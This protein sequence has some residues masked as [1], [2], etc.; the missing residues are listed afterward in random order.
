MSI[1]HIIWQLFTLEAPKGARTFTSNPLPNM[2][3]ES[4]WTI[5]YEFLCYLLVPLVGLGRPRKS[6]DGSCWP[7]SLWRMC[8]LQ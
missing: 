1:R 8:C 4:L 7:V 3:N 5:Q 2:V 6:E